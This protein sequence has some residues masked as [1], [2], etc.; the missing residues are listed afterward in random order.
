LKRAFF[1]LLL[2][3]CDEIFFEVGRRALLGTFEE[4]TYSESNREGSQDY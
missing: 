4:R 3:T 2:E 1:G